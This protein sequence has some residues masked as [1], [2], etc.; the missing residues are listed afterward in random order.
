MHPKHFIEKLDEAKIVEAI[1]RAEQTTSG[2]IRVSV[3]HRHPTDALG[4]AREHFLNSGM[5]R[6]PGR[7][8]V[9]IYFVPRA[10][11]FAIWG[12]MGLNEKCG[13][14]FW[15]DSAKRITA[16]LKAGQLTQAIEEAVQDVGAVLAQHFPR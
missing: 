6:T 7:H 1:R 3:S 4:A 10:Q 16:R 15:E 2:D 8:A 11:T 9:L 13:A 14:K 5:A 12:D